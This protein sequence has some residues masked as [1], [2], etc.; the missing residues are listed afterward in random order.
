[1]RFSS[2]IIIISS[3]YLNIFV[4]AENDCY[5]KGVTWSEEGTEYNQDIKTLAT[6]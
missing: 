4:I 6:L 2:T 3:Y 1:M 5:K